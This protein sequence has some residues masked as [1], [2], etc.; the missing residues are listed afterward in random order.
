MKL[1]LFLFVAL[2]TFLC[3]FPSGPQ[4]TPQ[5]THAQQCEKIKFDPNLWGNEF[6][7]A[8]TAAGC[9]CNE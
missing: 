9:E 3:A 2:L 5:L 7:A 8:M 1:R 4:A 6:V